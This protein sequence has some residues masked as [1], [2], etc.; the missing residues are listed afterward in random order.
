MP[1]IE[2]WPRS[3]SNGDPVVGHGADVYIA[4][5]F[6]AEEL[7]AV[8]YGCLESVFECEVIRG[9]WC[10]DVG[11]ENICWVFPGYDA[12]FVVVWVGVFAQQILQSGRESGI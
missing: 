10:T 12:G 7:D 1:R 2:I 9:R 3:V 6:L 11:A 8:V 5:Y 4:H